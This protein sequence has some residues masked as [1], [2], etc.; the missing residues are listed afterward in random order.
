MIRMS[1]LPFAQAVLTCSKED[2][3]ARFNPREKSLGG[4]H[5]LLPSGIHIIKHS[6][7][8]LCLSLVSLTATSKKY[9]ERLDLSIFIIGIADEANPIPQRKILDSH[10]ES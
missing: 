8:S 9:G 1:W 10:L 2:T 5:S 7:T 6:A 4:H 3:H